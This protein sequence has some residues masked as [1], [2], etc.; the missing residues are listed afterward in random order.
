MT[1]DDFKSTFIPATRKMFA[2]A[3]MLLSSDE[4][5]EDAVQ[6]ALLRL[7]EIRDRLHEVSSPE[8]FAVTTVRNVCLN[9]MRARHEFVQ[10]TE[11]KDTA[12]SHDDMETVTETEY[13]LDLIRRLP[14][15][16]QRVI[17]LS[18]FGECD[19]KEIS[20][21]TGESEGNVRLLLSRARKTLKSL[22]K[23]SR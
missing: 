8:A 12:E 3:R 17:R 10:A 18:S 22:Y 20:R 11:I 21:L 6:S 4:D 1:R 19:N 13:L 9:S 5:A 16:Q 23:L 2:V 14:D 15:K 7:W